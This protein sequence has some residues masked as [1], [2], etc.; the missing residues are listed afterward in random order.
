[1]FLKNFAVIEAALGYAPLRHIVNTGGIARF[2]EYHFDMVRLGIGL[3]GI[4]SSGLQEQLRVV[5]TLKATISQ[6]KSVP[7]GETVGYNRNGTVHRSSRIATISVGYADGFLRLAGGGRYA[8]GIH[9]RLAPTVGNVCMD[10]SMVDVTDIP[11]AR[12]GDE[13]VVFGETPPVQDLAAALQTIPYEVFTNI[14]ER[15]KRVYWQ[16]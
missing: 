10:M 12:E 13:V 1:L 14:S 4:D 16:E 7:S 3:Y 15:V 6:V 8:V 2:P 11:E 9:N 5:N